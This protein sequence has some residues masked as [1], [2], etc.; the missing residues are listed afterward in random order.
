MFDLVVTKSA[1]FVPTAFIA[2]TLVCPPESSFVR[3]VRVVPETVEFLQ[4]VPVPLVVPP[5]EPTHVQLVLPPAAGKAVL[6]D[7]PA[8]HWVSAP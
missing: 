3:A 5:P 7:A 2:A 4:A 1:K 8:E 6:V